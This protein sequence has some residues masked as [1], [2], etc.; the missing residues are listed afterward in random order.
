MSIITYEARDAVALLRMDDGKANAMGY[1]LLDELDAALDRAEREASAVVVVGRAGRFCAGFDLG[2]MMG[3]IERVR[4][5][6]TRGAGLLT[7]LYGLPMPVVAACT[8]HALAGGAL[9]LLTA[10]VRVAARG[11]YKIG[12]NEVQIGMPLPVLGIE[13]CRDRLSP[14]HLMA[15]TLFATVV[16][17]EGAVVAGWVDE[18]ADDASVV[19]VAAERAKQLSALPRVAYGKTKLALRERTI[20]YVRKTLAEDMARLT[21]PAK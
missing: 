8:G 4:A 13:L 16:D 1:A 15:S 10:D 18:L 5:L 21:P 11:R 19:D 12:L 14:M 2:E 3:G 20:E 17:P 6:V 7:R 9:M